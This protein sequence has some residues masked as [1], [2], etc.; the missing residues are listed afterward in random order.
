MNSEAPKPQA[1]PPKPEFT[2]VLP[3]RLSQKGILIVGLPVLIQLIFML[4][5]LS[6][7]ARIDAET[8]SEER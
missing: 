8:R 1:R 4:I 2:F 3:G 5:I 6:E 7:N